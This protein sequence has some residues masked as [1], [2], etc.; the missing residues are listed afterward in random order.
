MC[1]AKKSPRLDE[2]PVKGSGLAGETNQPAVCHA[3]ALRKATR[4]MSQLYDAALA[5]IGLRS[6][7][8]SILRQINNAGE[9]SMSELA[10]AL[11]LDRSALNHNLKPL[12]R[13]GLLTVAVAQED[14]RGRVV[15]LTQAGHDKLQASHSL[16]QDAQRRFESI[17]P[18][19]QVATLTATLALIASPEFT[20]KFTGTAGKIISRKKANKFAR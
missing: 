17:I 1:A 16:W 7:Q 11:V 6:T 3:T 4:R 5:P 18:S 13:D 14:K 2:I 12:E 9:L 10:E 8:R 19:S 15:R 20:D